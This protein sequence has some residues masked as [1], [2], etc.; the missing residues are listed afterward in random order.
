[1]VLIQV[2]TSCLWSVS[3]SLFFKK[4]E[5]EN[6]LS[7]YFVQVPL[8][9][10]VGRCVGGFVASFSVLYLARE[11]VVQHDVSHFVCASYAR[12]VVVAGG[13]SPP[14]GGAAAGHHGDLGA[15]VV[16]A[17]DGRMLVFGVGAHVSL[18]V[19][20]PPLPLDLCLHL[21]WIWTILL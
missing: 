8:K 10:H 21:Q 6:F 7:L 19:P 14:C 4:H 9:Q 13:R 18:Q 17:A 16:A 20:P 15:E 2:W 3:S 1:M 5:D 11:F 12:Q